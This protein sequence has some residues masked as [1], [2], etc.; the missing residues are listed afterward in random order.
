MSLAIVVAIACMAS[1]TALYALGLYYERRADANRIAAHKVALAEARRLLAEAEEDARELREMLQAS[2]KDLQRAFERAI[3]AE[4]IAASA[5]RSAELFRSAVERIEKEREA[6]RLE[7]RHLVGRLLTKGEIGDD[8]EPK[9]LEVPAHFQAQATLPGVIEVAIRKRANTP[10]LR[11]ELETFAWMRLS[12]L[13]ETGNEERR[14]AYVSDIAR[15]LEQ[16]AD[17]SALI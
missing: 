9:P 1:G 4:R 12:D 11:K 3:M 8:G 7:Y 14:A 10:Q 6:E 13:P 16:G 2:G 5:E 17:L 15:E